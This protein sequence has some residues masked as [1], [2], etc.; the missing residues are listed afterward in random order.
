[1]QYGQRQLGFTIVELLI[2]IVVI[3]ILAAITIVAYNGIQAQAYNSAVQSD[4]ANIEKAMRIYRE[5]NGALPP[6][7]DFYSGTS[8]PPTSRWDTEVLQAMRDANIISGDGL[9]TDPWGRYYWYDN[10]DCAIGSNGAS[11]LQSAGPDG[12]NNTSDDIRIYIRT[13]C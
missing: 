3:A 6:G 13:Y 10:N 5:E 2:V 12:L 1:M 8:N 9:A 11:P 7:V 4:L